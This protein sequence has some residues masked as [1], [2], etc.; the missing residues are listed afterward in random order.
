MAPVAVKPVS[1]QAA[2]L[3][4][5]APHQAP[6]AETVERLFDVVAGSLLLVLAVVAGVSAAMADQ[7]ARQALRLIGDQSF[8]GP[9]V[10]VLGVQEFG[11]LLVALVL[12]ARVGA[13][14]AAELSTLAVEGTLQADALF[15]LD[16][17]RRRLLPMAVACVVGCVVLGALAMVVWEM[18]GMAALWLRF[19]VNPFT[20]FHPEAVAPAMLLQHLAKTTLF[21]LCVWAAA[22]HAALHAPTHGDV[23]RATT[24]AVVSGTVAVLLVNLIVDVG[25]FLL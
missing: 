10:I 13:G 12:A 19:S 16:P 22:V 1:F 21:G 11:P 24:A 8:I 15:G 6:V 23:G 17:V 5:R 18:A 4:L 25:W 20:F 7:A 3:A 9:E 2:V 14:F